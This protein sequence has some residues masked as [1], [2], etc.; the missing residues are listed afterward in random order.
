MK[1]T[2]PFVTI[3]FFFLTPHEKLGHSLPESSFVLLICVL[4]LPHLSD[5]FNSSLPFLHAAV[6]NEITFYWRRTYIEIAY[7]YKLTCF[8][9]LGMRRTHEGQLYLCELRSTAVV[10]E[11]DKVY[12]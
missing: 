1:N 7:R 5:T 9:A 4:L 11:M 3:F 10:Q 2:I 6:V 12:D 8:A